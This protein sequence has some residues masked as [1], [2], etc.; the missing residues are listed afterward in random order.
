MLID[1]NTQETELEEFTDYTFPTHEFSLGYTDSHFEW[2][3]AATIF[4]IKKLKIQMDRFSSEKE[5]TGIS[6]A[7]KA[8]WLSKP[9]L[10]NKL[11]E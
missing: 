11:I 5:F 8:L 1:E 9:N 4:N 10:V 6:A 3:R 2:D 7:L